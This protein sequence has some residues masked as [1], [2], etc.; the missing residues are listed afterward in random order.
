MQ[1]ERAINDQALADVSWEKIAAP[2]LVVARRLG[3]VDGARSLRRRSPRGF[4]AR[5]TD[6]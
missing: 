6:G 5:N 3:F 4:H 1:V 2:V